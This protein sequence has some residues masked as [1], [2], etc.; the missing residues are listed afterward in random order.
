MN[1][2]R[3]PGWHQLLAS[4]CFA[5]LAAAAGYS[6]ALSRHPLAVAACV[7]AVVLGM[8]GYAWLTNRNRQEQAERALTE[9]ELRLQLVVN[10]S[11]V[12]IW[13]SDLRTGRTYWNQ[14]TF[15][16]FGYAPTP[17]GSVTV[18]MWN[19]RLHADDRELVRSAFDRALADRVNFVVEHRIV[20]GDGEVVWLSAYGRYYYDE[21]GRPVRFAGLNLD[22]T[23]LKRAQEELRAADRRKDEFL[24]IL[25]HEL[26]NPLAPLRDSLRIFEHHPDTDPMLDAARQIMQRQTGQMVRLIDDL[27][28]VSRISRNRLELRK[29]N[30]TIADVIG[31]ALETCGP[32]ISAAG[33]HLSLQLPAEPLPVHGDRVRLTQVFGNLLSNSAK[34]TPPGGEISVTAARDG[35]EVVVS[36]RDT[37]V[38]IAT[39]DLPRVFEMFTQVGRGSEHRVGGL[40]IG[41]ALVY[42]LVK[43]HGGSVTAASAGPGRGSEF[44]VRLALSTASPAAERTAEASNAR[45]AGDRKKVLVTDDNEDAATALALLLTH[46]GNDVQIAHDGEEALTVAAEFRPDLIL[47]DVGMP[48]LDGLEVTRRLRKTEWG[49]RASIVALTGWGQDADKRRSQEAGADD[50]LVKP[51]DPQVLERVLATLPAPNADRLRA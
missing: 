29:E 4:A 47:M 1:A 35:G 25:A 43:M 44:S 50:H 11:G 33:H 30:T 17:D 22:I 28:D 40:G 10:G 39:E 18:E 13:D 7:A 9:S 41:L 37:G 46:M 5:A 14:R 34:Y 26:R 6:L 15:E 36:I 51:V 24:A 16:L 42:R 38:G 31:S 45:P 12:A 20:R 49:R 19:A 3:P 27:L 23:Q 32:M 8:G 21:R 48:R 2:H